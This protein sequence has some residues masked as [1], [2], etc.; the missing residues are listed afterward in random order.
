MIPV[1][2]LARCCAT[3][4]ARGSEYLEDDLD[5]MELIISHGSRLPLYLTREELENPEGLLHFED[6]L[7]FLK[8]GGCISE[9]RSLLACLVFFKNY[10]YVSR[11]HLPR[12]ILSSIS[13]T[14]TG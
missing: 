6:C 12:R 14:T 11:F 9:V 4:G 10:S 2:F 3:G 13:S 7:A 8:R 5:A 1:L